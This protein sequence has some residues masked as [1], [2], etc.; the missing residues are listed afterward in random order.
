MGPSAG[1]TSYSGPSTIKEDSKSEQMI[2]V[3]LSAVV[4]VV[5]PLSGALSQIFTNNPNTS[6]E[7]FNFVSTW[8]EARVLAQT[9][10]YVPSKLN[11]TIATDTNFYSP[12]VWAFDRVAGL[13]A[14]ASIALAFQKADSK[15]S[16]IQKENTMRVRAG[17]S[18][19]MLF[20]ATASI[21]P[22]WQV[23]L[24]SDTVSPSASYG[25]VFIEYLV[26]LR[27]RA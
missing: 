13:S 23:T 4:P 12:C 6:T 18:Q 24:T 14:P 17:S 22:T 19:E 7:W 9:V 2:V 25:V 15:A 5:A 26:Q 21:A 16:S 27:N 1:A 20:Q 11:F 8:E 3:R 10:H